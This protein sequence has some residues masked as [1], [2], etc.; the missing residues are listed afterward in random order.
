[1]DYVLRGVPIGAGEHEVEFRYEPLTWRIGWLI[2]LAALVALAFALAIGW[3][4]RR[5]VAAPS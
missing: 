3:R 5:R 4:R 1:V 2:S